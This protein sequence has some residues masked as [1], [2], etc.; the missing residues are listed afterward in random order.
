[1]CKNNENEVNEKKYN[2]E[3]VAAE[4]LRIRNID[5]IKDNRRP[6][7]RICD[8]IKD[9]WGEEFIGILLSSDVGFK[10]LVSLANELYWDPDAT[11]ALRRMVSNK[12]VTKEQKERFNY[13]LNASKKYGKS[14]EEKE[15]I[16]NEYNMEMKIKNQIREIRNQIPNDFSDTY[17]E[18]INL[19]VRTC[20]TLSEAKED[21]FNVN[22]E[23]MNILNK[24]IRKMKYDIEG[25][26]LLSEQDKM[27]GAE[28]LEK[29]DKLYKK[30]EDI[31]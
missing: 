30:Y 25:V 17:D 6:V 16:E 9:F 29:L 10:K 12:N 8:S 4:V 1:M 24:K 22:E 11:K 3:N 31:L 14:D 7:R 23:I 13:S 15:K 19:T 21:I 5:N 20:T 18:Y 2:I 28:F 26:E 27:G